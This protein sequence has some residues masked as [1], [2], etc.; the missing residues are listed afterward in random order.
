MT[1]IAKI[2]FA[3]PLP[4]L[5]R[6][7]DYLVPESM[8]NLK[9][10]QLVKVPFGTEKKPKT[11]VVV[12]IA[13]ESSYQGTLAEIVSVE[14]NLS[15]LTVPQLQL[16]EAVATRFMGSIGE[17]LASVLPKRMIRVE[18][19][20]VQ[21]LAVS[22]SR[23][24]NPHPSRSYYQPSIARRQNYPN[25]AKKFA[26]VARE[27]LA[28]NQSVIVC[29]PDYRD[30][31]NLKLAFEQEGLVDKIY[32]IHSANSSSENYLS[33][34]NAMQ[35]A[36][37]YVGLRS[38][39]FLPARNL[40][41][42][43]VLDDGDESQ[44]DPGSPYWNTRDVALLRQSLED[45]DL[46]FSSLSPSTEVVRL[47][48]IGYLNH[49][50]DKDERPAV[51][52]T[53]S[54]DRLDEGTFAAISK[55]LKQNSAVLIQ[56]ANLG[57][58]TAIACVNCSELRTCNCGARIWI[59]TQRKYRCRS[60]KA[61]GDL[62]P[63]GCGATRVRT[64]RTG[65]SAMVEWLKKAFSEANVIHSS[66]EERITRIEPGPNLVIATPGSEPEV[67]GGY[68]YVVLADAYSM[69]GAPRLRA[70][71][72]SLL[73][74]ANAIEKTA[75]SG[76]VIFSGLTD[77][78]ADSMKGLQFFQAMRQDFLERE[79]LG[80]PPTRRIASITS[81]SNSDLD[82]LK[83]ELV[84]Q[85]GSRITPLNSNDTSTIH[86]CFNYSEAEAITPVLRKLVSKISSKSKNRLPGQRLFR[87]RMDDPNAI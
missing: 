63:C 14:S 60:C 76:V 48:E 59:D 49:V 61:T 70:L 58:A 47:V 83:R 12:G 35:S 26:E 4:A 77:Q 68:S 46:I 3:S 64:I 18:K 54:L 19:D 39:I 20:F 53:D 30:I 33:Y 72:K 6:E 21:G 23:E 65:S 36:G 84:G 87:V 16:I 38:S 75:P 15:L 86:F 67:F 62:P 9:L 41:I 17:L 25:W 52:I 74:W 55:S 69:V 28:N 44:I 50:A 45:C 2:R 7:F 78:L 5:D 66:A 43:L 42:I 79:E 32:F 56:I 82:V 11:G 24:S 73:L 8:Y 31:E 37:V 40:G 81:K 13:T 85:L 71:E 34:L 80:L 10:G 29:L 57:F 27:Y 22:P 1:L 51:R